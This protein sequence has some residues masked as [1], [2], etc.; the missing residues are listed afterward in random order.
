M[1]GSY[2]QINF[3]LRPA[4]SIE[5]KMLCEAFRRLAEF[6][7]VS[8]YRYIGFG[9]TYFSDFILVHKTLAIRNML[10]IERDD[11]NKARFEFNRPFHCIK[12]YFGESNDVLPELGWRDVRTICWLDYD[13]KLDSSVL[14]DVRLFCANAVSGSV[15][16]VTVNAEPDQNPPQARWTTLGSALERI[17]FPEV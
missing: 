13:G 15:L 1:T 6:G 17:W 2:R 9:S 16:V 4:K 10:S 12:L 3:S 8:D 14:T 11:F 5:R 7:H